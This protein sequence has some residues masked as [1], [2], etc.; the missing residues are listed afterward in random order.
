LSYLLDT[1]VFL[2][3]LSQPGRLNSTATQLLLARSSRIFL[4]A[5]TSWELSIKYALKKISLPCEPAKLIPQVLNDFGYLS[6]EIRHVHATA[7][8][9]L[10]LHHRDPFDR[11]LIAQAHIENLTLMT[12][13]RTLARYGIQILE[14]GL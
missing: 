6:L 5:A 7:V 2:W 9:E 13:D 1:N 14:C 8:V 3:S 4:S 11:L 10:P 12:P